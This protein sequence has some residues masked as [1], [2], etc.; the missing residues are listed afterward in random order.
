MIQTALFFI[1]GFLSACFLAVL[2]APAIWRR[3][4]VLTRRRLEA[5]LPLTRA[6]IQADKDRVRAEYAIAMRRLEMK[7][8]TLGEKS[9]GQQ[10]ELGRNREEFVRLAAGIESRDRAAAEA[11]RQIEV[12]SAENLQRAGRIAGLEQTVSDL[13]SRLEQQKEETERIGRMYDE[14]SFSASSRQI[15]IVAQESKLEKLSDDIARLRA[16][17]K[18][19]DAELREARAEAKAA[20]MALRDERK[21]S[22]ALEKKLA[23]MTSSLADSED[24]LERRLQE[25]KRLREDVKTKG[26]GQ[27]GN[28]GNG[29]AT[30]ERRRMEDRLTRITQENR[31]LRAAL[32][33]SGKADKDAP[34]R[35]EENA[36]LRERVADLAAEVVNMTAL[37]EGPDSPVWKALGEDAASSDGSL[38]GR[39]RALRDAASRGDGG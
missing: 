21:K 32:A 7:L 11:Q 5:T 29:L 16:A 22:E 36:L 24:K 23:A 25:V 9:A 3:A 26:R 28:A 33:E 2:V 35:E 31:K 20:G 17:R 12:L 8:K 13:E 18:Q 15:E 37:L 34:E 19:G 10:V 4:V 1:L 6:E 39:I 27:G 14:A 30:E 38:A